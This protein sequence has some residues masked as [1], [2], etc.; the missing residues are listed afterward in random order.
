MVVVHGE[1]M[2]GKSSLQNAIRWCMYGYALGR[3]GAIKPTYRLISYDALD[4]Q[5]FVT[6]V[7][8]D[9]AHDGYRYRLQRSVQSEVVPRS[10]ADLTEQLSLTKDGSFLPEQEIP[11]V[12]NGILHKRIARFFLFD[13]EMLAQYEEL[14]WDSGRSS[15][16]IRGSIEQILG[17]PALQLARKDAAELRRVAERDQAKAV[18]G[19]KRAARLI[20]E[21]EQLQDEVDSV[22]R[23][24]QTLE[25]LRR[26]YT[27]ARDQAAERRE[28]Y[29]EIQAELHE[30]DRLE[31]SIA[32]AKQ[33]QEN[34][35]NEI[36]TLLAEGWWEPVSAIA[37]TKAE[38][39]ES[40]AAQA[41][42]VA[43]SVEVRRQ[44]LNQLQ[45]LISKGV[46]PV[47]KQAADMQKDHQKHIDGLKQEIG[48]F[49]FRTR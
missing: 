35:R 16:L 36:R 37:V 13:G 14:M 33:T 43:K 1:N 41:L 6:R 47:C 34:I 18:R 30:A 4:A 46:C 11:R 40:V 42:D 15:H 32:A 2:R 3:G 10:D 45:D 44:L 12:I 9:F 17:L 48:G 26:K 27:E 8:I 29:D 21:A 25:D 7:T 20:R 23:D 24:L 39:L 5:Q 22:G 28:R 31:E 19:V 38:K 49:I